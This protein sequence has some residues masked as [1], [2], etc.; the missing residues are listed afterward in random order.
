MDTRKRSESIP[1][2]CP[3]GGP[4]HGVPQTAVRQGL[5]DFAD[6][7]PHLDLKRGT[8]TRVCDVGWKCLTCG[9]QWGFEVLTDE[10]LGAQ[11]QAAGGA[12][13]ASR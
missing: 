12:P 8:I 3:R 10:Y 6:V 5:A 4:E 13:D 11:D 1:P 9:Q 7:Y 2:A